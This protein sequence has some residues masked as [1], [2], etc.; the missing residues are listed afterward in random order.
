MFLYF[1]VYGKTLQDVRSYQNVKLHFDAKKCMKS[2]QS[3]TFKRSIIINKQLVLT[4]HKQAKVL[5]DKPFLVG[6][7]IL[8]LSKFH[9]YH[10][11]YKILLKKVDYTNVTLL[12]TDTGM[13]SIY[14]Y[15]YIFC[16]LNCFLFTDSFCF[17]INDPNFDLKKL[18]NCFDFSNYP[19]SHPWFSK[20]TENV[21]GLVSTTTMTNQCLDIP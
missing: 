18:E 1:T 12:F 19:S 16:F 4:L 3:P 17:A 2:V 21:T 11:W 15:S 13:Y 5:L 8:D 7:T 10:F 20:D 9:M 6:Q 14:T